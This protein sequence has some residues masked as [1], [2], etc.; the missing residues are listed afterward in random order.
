MNNYSHECNGAVTPDKDVEDK[1]KQ[2][3]LEQISGSEGDTKFVLP[4][5]K[6]ET[7][8]EETLESE[9]KYENAV[10]EIANNYKSV[11]R[12]LGEDT[13]RQGLLKTPERAAKAMMFFTKGYRENI[14]GLYL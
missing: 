1:L 9:K 13:G 7:K 2:L 8:K 10:E 12:S 3:K 11:L 14:S 6:R 4:A 5:L